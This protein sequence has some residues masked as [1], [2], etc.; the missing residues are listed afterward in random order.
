[1]LLTLLLGDEGA[2]TIARYER[3]FYG[4]IKWEWFSLS[5]TDQLVKGQWPTANKKAQM[6]G[7]DYPM[8]IYKVLAYITNSLSMDLDLPLV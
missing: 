1:M 7:L 8:F 4:H 6:N 5:M 2:T 3:I